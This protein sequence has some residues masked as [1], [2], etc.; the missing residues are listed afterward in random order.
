[1]KTKYANG[2]IY[3]LVNSVDDKIYIGGTVTKYLSKRKGAHKMS[4]AKYPNRKVYKHLNQIGWG[5]VSI[6]L[7]EKYPCACKNELLKRER[8]WTDRLK[9]ELNMIKAIRTIDEKR[10]YQQLYR[11]NNKEMCNRKQKQYKKRKYEERMACECGK[12]IAKCNY[13]RHAK[14]RCHISKMQALN[15]K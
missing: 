3:K 14:L 5:N 2:K 4:S 10:N 1:M 7:I 8:Y 6:K 12:D 11:T 13:K 15:I 9:S